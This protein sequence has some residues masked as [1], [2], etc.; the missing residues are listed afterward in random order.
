MQITIDLPHVFNAH[1]SPRDNAP[2]LRAILDCMVTCNL[3]FL[4]RY[5]DTPVLYRAGIR[6]GRTTIW[7]SIPAL[8]DRQYGDCKSLATALIAEYLNKGK[9]AVPCFRW[10]RK[11]VGGM[12]FHIL[13]QTKLGF[14]DPSRVLGMGWDENEWF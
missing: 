4:R 1:A 7:D 14:E 12:D 6:Y 13:V 3:D 5:P 2:A 9:Q 10:A 8:Y 11:P